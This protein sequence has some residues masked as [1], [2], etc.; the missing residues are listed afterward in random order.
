[1][2]N[3][4]LCLVGSILSFMI[5]Y[6]IMKRLSYPDIDNEAM[7]AEPSGSTLKEGDECHVWDGSICRRGNVV[8]NECVSEGSKMPMFF[9][10]AG[11]VLLV[12][13]A[14]LHFMKGKEE[15]SSETKTPKDFNFSVNGKYQNW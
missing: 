15:S 13:S 11:F 12:A 9:M 10:G 8:N 5:S 4:L 6:F 14:V 7:C 3:A 2:S 1:M